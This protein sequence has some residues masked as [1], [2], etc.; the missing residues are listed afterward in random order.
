M[1]LVVQFDD[2]NR[3]LFEE[4]GKK[5]NTLSGGSLNL[6]K[7]DNF[8]LKIYIK[9]NGKMNVKFWELFERDRKEYRK[10][11]H[12]PGNLIGKKFEGE[13]IFSLDNIYVVKNKEGRT[14]SKKHHFCC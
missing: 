8:Y 3:K 4:F 7:V 1:S 13:A 6:V 2:D 12:N 10:P 5:F 9:P 11:L 14:H